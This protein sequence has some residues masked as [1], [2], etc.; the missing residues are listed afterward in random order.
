MW[1]LGLAYMDRVNRHHF[2]LGGCK[3]H[4]RRSYWL[5]Y[6]GSERG[7]SASLGSDFLNMSNV[8]T[9]RRIPFETGAF[10]MHSLLSLHTPPRTSASDPLRES[11]TL[12]FPSLP[13]FQVRP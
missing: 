11:L 5:A 4:T 13:V 9:G 8:Q 1:E 7:G 3:T 2:C 6:H 10:N 12:M